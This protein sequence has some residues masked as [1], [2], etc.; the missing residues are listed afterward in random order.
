MSTQTRSNGTTPTSAQVMTGVSPPHSLQAEQSVLGGILLSDRAMYGL[1]IEEGLKAE[2][3]YR[4]RHRLIYDAMCRLYGD[5]EPV[6]VLTVADQLERTGRLN[7]AGGKAA[8]DELTG[9]VP[10]LGAIRRYAQIVREHALMRRLLSTTYEI[11]ASVLNHAAA[12]R[13]LVEQ[14]E[15]AIFELGQTSRRTRDRPLQESLAAEIDRIEQAAQTGDAV[16][17]LP[18]GFSGLDEM[19]NGLHPGRMY[20][21][22]ARPAMGKTTLVQNIAANL[23]LRQQRKVLFASLEMGEPELAQRHLAAESGVAHHRIE[24]AQLRDTDWPKLLDSV[25]AAGSAR[26]FTLDEPDLSVFDLRNHA[27]QVSV[28]EGGLD[29]VV[30]DYLQLMRADPP[31]N[32]RTEDVSAFSRGLKRLSRELDCAVIAVAQLSRQVEQRTDKRPLLS[33]LRESGQ[34]EADADAVIMLYRDDYYHEDSDKP[35]QTELLIRKN[36]QGS[37]GDCTIKLLPGQRFID[38]PTSTQDRSPG[39]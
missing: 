37:T 12:P 26:F 35:G 33:D 19:L 9:G 25:K 24:R 30:V 3:F 4:E 36:R 1:V 6:D 32:N 21:I 16:T 38:L 23:A 28:R 5:G 17:G 8:I 31:S 22:A 11:Q 20:V 15:R 2:D 13:E 39:W 29:L 14:A 10:G 18:T 34:I 7:D 27:R